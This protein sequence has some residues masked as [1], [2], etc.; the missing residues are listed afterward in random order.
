M[1]AV[2]TTTMTLRIKTEAKGEEGG[3]KKTREHTKKNELH[4]EAEL[5]LHLLQSQRHLARRGVERH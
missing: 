3:S 1:A 4:L 5:P 2:I